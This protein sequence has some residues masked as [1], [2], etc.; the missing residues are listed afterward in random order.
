M[1]R[2]SLVLFAVFHASQAVR[3]LDTPAGRLNHAY[4]A[5][6][7]AYR[8][9]LTRISVRPV[10]CGVRYAPMR[11]GHHATMLLRTSSTTMLHYPGYAAKVRPTLSCYATPW[12]RATVILDIPLGILGYLIRYHATQ[13]LPRLR[14]ESVN[15]QH[16]SLTE[17][18]KGLPF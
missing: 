14:K 11:A 2:P 8:G 4:L 12:V 9:Y 10:L 16:R 3:C 1:A 15:H 7:H 18:G 17:H 5:S 6:F 13:L